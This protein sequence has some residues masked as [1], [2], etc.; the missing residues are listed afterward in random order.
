MP[1]N[2]NGSSAFAAEI[3]RKIMNKRGIIGAEAQ[4][5]FLAPN[6]RLAYDPF[7]LRNMEAGVDLL[8][9]AIS[10]QKHIVIYG[11][12]DCDG[13]TATALLMKVLRTVTDKVSY[14]IPSRMEEGYGLHC[15]AI[16]AIKDDGG[17]VIVTV[18][19]G[20]VSA[21]EAEYAASLGIEMVITDHHEVRDVVAP[22]IV[23]NPKVP[24]DTY[25]FRGLAGVGVAYKLALALSKRMD[26][27]RCVI[28]EVLELVAVGT[29]GDIMP[30]L[31]E[32]RSLVKYGLRLM[33]GGCCNRGLKTLLRMTETPCEELLAEDI[34]FQ[35]VPRINA[36]G[37]LGDASLGVKAL[38]A[39]TQEEADYY[40]R[41]LM[42]INEKR[43]EMQQEAYQRLF[44]AAK[45]EAEF[46]DFLLVE[47]KD[48][49]EGILGIVAG[50]LKEHFRRPVAI[51]T[52]NEGH[53]KGTS[54]SIDGLDI[55]KLLS[56]HRNM[57]SAFGGHAKAC[58]FT[59]EPEDLEELRFS[60]NEEVALLE[61]EDPTIFDKKY[62]Y[63]MEL[64]PADV[65]PEFV[66][67]LRVLEPCGEK[68][69]RPVALF[70]AVYL[71][72]WSFLGSG[73][74]YARFR[75]EKNG[76]GIDGIL[77]QNALEVHGLFEKGFPV[78]VYGKM[79]IN[80]WNG[81][82]RLQLEVRDVIPAK[83]EEA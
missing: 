18:D 9:H 1:E 64:L 57:F 53:L 45:E 25:P 4:E 80:R 59:M 65:T 43:R 66:K 83:T 62:K 19:C 54:R 70:R 32:N 75:I 10:E 58:G 3:I 23:I 63:D 76:S 52:E 5:E 35:I 74:S 46:G 13:V 68:N 78:D 67:A 2:R 22:G 27:P 20:S 81:R 12:Y 14:Y 26:I 40:C 16:D 21:K 33:R 41:R 50:K 6:P 29:I 61:E 56:A 79:S 36:A 17:E 48:E 7:L 55:F 11:D 82:E 44:A 34:S 31:D 51:V 47:A 73:T 49:H 38:L 77:F 42:E 15:D 60:L 37:R 69:E 72:N 39:E 28:T 71:E 24:G 8:L 30:L